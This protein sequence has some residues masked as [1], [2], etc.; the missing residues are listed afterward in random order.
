MFYRPVCIMK[1]VCKQ[2]CISVAKLINKA[3]N[4]GVQNVGINYSLSNLQRKLEEL[5]QS[6]ESLNK[7]YVARK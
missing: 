2:I 7:Y 5:V 4:D 1:L 3:V 6:T